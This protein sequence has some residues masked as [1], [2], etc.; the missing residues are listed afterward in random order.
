[1]GKSVSKE[2]VVIAQNAGGSNSADITQFMA[3][4]STTSILLLMIVTLFICGGACYV[5]LM[6]YKKC[7]GHLMRQ[8]I[9]RH[10]L[11][12]VA[13]RVRGAQ[14]TAEVAYKAGDV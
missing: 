14:D 4:A 10:S 1:M 9:L 7:H 13:P 2:E 8:E 6:L 5:L 3:H 12:R 11:R